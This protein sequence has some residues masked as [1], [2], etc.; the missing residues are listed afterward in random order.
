MNYDFHQK[1]KTPPR[2]IRKIRLN[3]IALVMQGFYFFVK[4]GLALIYI[5]KVYR[6]KSSSILIRKNK[7]KN[8]IKIRIKFI[9]CILLFKN[10]YL[11]KF[12]KIYMLK[13]LK[14]YSQIYLSEIIY[15]CGSILT[16]YIT[17]GAFSLAC[18]LSVF[19]SFI[20]SCFFL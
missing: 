8:K 7:N 1:I 12:W 17:W 15:Y 10:I 11:L 3:D 18:V 13:I 5:L 6:K 14:I 20:L 2:S 9:T 4:F 16:L 19:F